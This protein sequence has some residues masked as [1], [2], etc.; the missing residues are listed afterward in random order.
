MRWATHCSRIPSP[1]LTLAAIVSRKKPPGK[2]VSP[3]Q[4]QVDREFRIMK[5]LKP[6]GFPV[7]NVLCF[8][9]DESV[10][11]TPFFIM[12]FVEGRIFSDPRLPKVPPAERRAYWEAAVKTLAALHRIDFKKIG[13]ENYGKNSGYYERSLNSFMKLHD[14]QAVV[15]DKDTG[16]PVGSFDRIED[17]RKWFS[18]NMP[19]DRATIFHGDY[20]FD[21]FIF[22]PTEPRVGLQWQL[23]AR[24]DETDRRGTLLSG[25]RRP[26]LGAFDHWS[27]SC[28]RCQPFDA[29]LPSGTGGHA[30]LRQPSRRDPERRGN[31]EA[32]RR[33]SRNQVPDRELEGCHCVF[34]LPWGCYRPGN[35]SFCS[36]TSSN[37]LLTP[38]VLQRSPFRPTTKQQPPCPRL[39][40]S[41][42]R[43]DRPCAAND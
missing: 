19:E 14:Q 42:S 12:D 39:R 30:G 1:F 18:K 41:L 31:D 20:K 5:A 33:R 16:V 7:P 10:L 32:V 43:S 28:R 22:H 4:H 3:T 8:C 26:R 13:L 24:S 9:A 27:S 21:N 2:I 35:V 37:S 34:V 6:T 29:L 11:G 38:V 25:H 23:W 36:A 40:L 15:K 17:M